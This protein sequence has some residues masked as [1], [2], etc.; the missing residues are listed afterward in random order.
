MICS[1]DQSPTYDIVS[2][3]KLCLSGLP[4]S[5]SIRTWYCL[6][7]AGGLSTYSIDT[8]I[9][10]KKVGTHIKK[11]LS[12]SLTPQNSLIDLWEYLNLT[13]KW[14]Y[15]ACL[16]FLFTIFGSK[17]LLTVPWS[18]FHPLIRNAFCPW[19][20]SKQWITGSRGTIKKD[21]QR[22]FWTMVTTSE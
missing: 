17:W 1:G 6:L 22:L 13:Q 15:S 5:H 14:H 4:K 20:N 18:Q 8:N 16:A 2:M 3:G 9:G 10:G 19:G 21:S 11:L 12:K 7:I